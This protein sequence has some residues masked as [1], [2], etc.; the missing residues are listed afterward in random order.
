MPLVCITDGWVYAVH[1]SW[2]YA[3]WM[4]SVLCERVHIYSHVLYVLRSTMPQKCKL[5]ERYFSAKTYEDDPIRAV[6]RKRRA[7]DVRLANNFLFP[8]KKIHIFFSLLS[9]ICFIGNEWETKSGLCYG[10]RSFLSLKNGWRKQATIWKHCVH[11][12]NDEFQHFTSYPWD[13]FNLDNINFVCSRF[14][15][16]CAMWTK[17]I[18]LT[19][20][21]FQLGNGN[22]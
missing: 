2:M 12:E 6:I 19:G 15:S 17:C 1:I 14:V 10:F 20:W 21:N 9:A 11:M 7:V 5:Q 18:H 22:S 4:G 8:W 13:C 16:V 3:T